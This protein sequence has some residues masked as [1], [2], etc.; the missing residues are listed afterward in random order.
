MKILY[1]HRIGSRD[2]QAVHLEELIGALRDLGHEVCLVGPE[3]FARASF[4]HEPQFIGIMKKCVPKFIYE[5]LE[6]GYNVPAFLRLTRTGRAFGPDIV[7]ERYN[8]YLL[9]GIWFRRFRG[10][11]LLLEVNAPL[12]RER[13]S[14]G[15]LGLGMLA[16]AL[17]RSVWRNADAVLPVT[18]VLADEVRAAGV[19]DARIT[20]IPNG[21]DVENFTGRDP[22]LAKSAFGLE[23]KLVVGFT[24]FVRD[25]HGLERVLTLLTTDEIPHNLHFMIVGDGPA[26]PALTTLATELGVADRVTFAGLVPRDRLAD[27]VSTFDI[28][29]LPKCVEYCSPLKLFEYMAAGKAI[30]APDQP[31]IREI[32]QDGASGLLFPPDDD[33][34]VKSAVIRLASDETLR[35]RL[36]ATARSEIAQRGLTWRNNA[37]RVASLG[38]AAA[39]RKRTRAA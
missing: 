21:T 12:A 11:P 31:N 34:G 7:Y 29:L 33:A 27:H 39:Q 25:W 17:E 5:L 28:A 16:R 15:G 9:A 18:G 38:T 4:G 19:P 1:H 35:A 14:F 8:L 10:I 6:I 36:G 30:L 3:S 20:V 23:G 26:I 13:A 22:G 32:L 2:G 24:G 37:V